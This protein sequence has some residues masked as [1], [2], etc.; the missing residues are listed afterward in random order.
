MILKAFDFEYFKELKFL[1]K[2]NILFFNGCFDIVHTGH[3]K[4]I[5]QIKTYGNNNY[6]GSGYKIICGLNS[7][8]SIKLQNKS[9]PLINSERERAKF[10][11]ELGVDYVIT[12]DEETPTALIMSLLPD[13]VFKGED[14]KSK[15]YDEREF[16]LKT[17]TEVK[18][19]TLEHGKSTTNIY[20]KIAE[21]VKKEI[22]ESII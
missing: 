22:R 20:N 21:H 4:L 16:L 19:I 1:K 17:N 5:N 14:Y 6:P 18:Y 12:F 13:K 15:N 11:E 2:K 3:L 8:K 9:H 7:D 10:L